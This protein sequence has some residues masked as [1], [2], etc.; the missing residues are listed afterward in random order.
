[1]S[2]NEA[3]AAAAEWNL[4]VKPRDWQRRALLA[5]TNNECRGIVDVVTGAGKT[6]FAEL[7]MEY[8]RSH[9]LAM[10]FT[11]IV[12]TL[13]LL[14]Q[15]Y[16][17]LTDELGLSKTDLAAYSGEG[18]PA[19]PHLVNLMVLNTARDHA[20]RL[21]E[22]E[23]RTF[24]IVDECHRAG[25]PEN[26]RA[27]EGP[28][29][30]SLGLSATPKRE[31]DEALEEIIA[32]RLGPI[33]YRY[34]YNDARADGVIAPYDLINAKVLL[35]QPE[36]E[37]YDAYTT[38]LARLMRLRRDGEDIEDRIRRLLRERASVSASAAMRIPAAVR[39]AEQHRGSRII[40]FHE[41]I[42]A[43]QTMLELLKAR[44]HQA[45]AYHSRLGPVMRR[46][47]L[48]LFRRGRF[49]V[50]V[51]CRALDEGVNVPEATVAIIASSTASTRQ[52]VQRLGRVLR[53]A[54]GKE[55]ALIYTIYATSI[56][57]RRLAEEA[58]KLQG[59][60]SVSWLRLA[61]ERHG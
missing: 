27:L 45:A 9:G 47:N 35:T 26:A 51:S 39:L 7:C 29:S 43:A 36:Q 38:R 16:V 14:D 2:R 20:P 5:W 24:L 37:R 23:H 4:Q 25:S 48:E 3:S 50:L 57:E 49:S 41:H 32:P 34:D 12:P 33:L 1:M 61:A 28:Y 31:Y 17:S 52:R 13:A 58:L 8:G 46:D 21:S 56:E 54:P 18:V 30:A 10:R 60:E 6:A 11:I 40:I 55:R 44:G 42:K 53:P 22:I 59:A 19:E 15:W